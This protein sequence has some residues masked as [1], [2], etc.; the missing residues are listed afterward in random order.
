MLAILAKFN[1]PLKIQLWWT[2]TLTTTI[3][4][5]WTKIRTKMSICTWIMALRTMGLQPSVLLLRWWKSLN[6]AR[7]STS[8]PSSS[9]LSRTKLPRDNRVSSHSSCSNNTSNS[10]QCKCLSTK[11]PNQNKTSLSNNRLNLITCPNLAWTTNAPN[12]P[13]SSNLCS[14]NNSLLSNRS[15]NNN[16]KHTT[17]SICLLLLR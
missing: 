2:I 17:L 1:L 8:L 15:I 6:R 10:S 5:I 13:L 9:S 11:H 3:M 12:L 14:D 16:S 4:A 7:C